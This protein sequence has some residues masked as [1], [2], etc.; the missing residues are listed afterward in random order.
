MLAFEIALFICLSINDILFIGYY[1]SPFLGTWA[2]KWNNLGPMNI[3]PV[4]LG[5]KV[6]HL[7]IIKCTWAEKWN[8]YP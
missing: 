2:E 5:R 1:W 7:P 6:E 4:H 3:F 8:I